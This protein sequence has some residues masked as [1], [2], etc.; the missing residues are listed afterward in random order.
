VQKETGLARPVEEPPLGP[1]KEK[2]VSEE[3]FLLYQK[4]LY[5]Y[6]PMDLDAKV[7]GIDEENSVWKRE[8]VSF[9]AAYGGERVPG[10]L[11]LPKRATP[12]YQTIIYAHPGMATRL[13]SPQPG[14]E[15]LYDFIV[16]NGRAF[17][18]PVL[19]GMYQRRYATATAGLNMSRDRLIEASKD[20]RR[21]IDYLMS[22]PDVDHDRL[23]VYGLSAY[24][25]LV[26]I[27]AVGEQR[28]KVAVFGSTGLGSN[29][30]LFLPETDPLNF[31]PHFRMPTLT[32][33]GRS[34]FGC[35]IELCQIPWLQRLGAQEQDKKLVHRDG[36]HFP[37][38]AH[39]MFK[40][41]LAWFDR[42]L[43]PVK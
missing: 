15:L 7:E 34:D 38:D 33:N 41:S 25:S 24:G 21:S 5:A 2:P 17:F 22:R 9:A 27:L 43:G 39:V 29:R 16:K 36:G 26:P 20:F 28:L 37:P 6:D 13:S 30:S 42:Y 12:P 23:G 4:T 40:E 10:Y 8:K 14:E 19:K 18:I 1:T 11:Y 3:V 35:S 32:I 31:L